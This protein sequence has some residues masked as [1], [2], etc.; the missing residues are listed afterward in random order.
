MEQGVQQALLLFL[1]HRAGRACRLRTPQRSQVLLC[2][3]LPC[4]CFISL[5]AMVC[6]ARHACQP[7]G[8]Y[9]SLKLQ[10]VLQ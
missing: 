1:C 10:R 9:C 3:E 5:P 2:C 8:S 6:P 7:C 4:C